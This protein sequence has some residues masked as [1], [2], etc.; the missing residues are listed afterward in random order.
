MVLLN[1]QEAKIQ[2]TYRQQWRDH[3]L[4]RNDY[5]AFGNN[6]IFSLF[7]EDVKKLWM[8]DTFM[9]KS[10]NTKVHSLLEPYM[11]AKVFLATGDVLSSMM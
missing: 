1:L 3:R 7:G 4:Q 11:Y 8:P 6:G 10:S 9:R 5:K 2:V